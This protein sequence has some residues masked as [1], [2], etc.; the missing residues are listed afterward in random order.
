MLAAAVR[1]NQRKTMTTWRGGG[2]SEEEELA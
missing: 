1:D 2:I